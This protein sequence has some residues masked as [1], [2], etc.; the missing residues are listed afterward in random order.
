MFLSYFNDI[1]LR[2]F[3]TCPTCRHRPEGLLVKITSFRPQKKWPRSW[4]V[5]GDYHWALGLPGLLPHEFC[6]RSTWSNEPPFFLHRA[7]ESNF[8][9]CLGIIILIGSYWILLVIR[10]HCSHPKKTHDTYASLWL[11]WSRVEPQQWY[12]H[13]SIIPWNTGWLRTGFPYIGLMIIIPNIY[14]VV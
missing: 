3:I 6:L 5:H 7:D 11:D 10:C 2:T 14:R 1:S 12:L 13:P 8:K 9:T 4:L